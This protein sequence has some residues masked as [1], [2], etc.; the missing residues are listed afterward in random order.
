MVLG[1]RAELDRDPRVGPMLAVLQNAGV[2]V[3]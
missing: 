2:H 3:A 1:N